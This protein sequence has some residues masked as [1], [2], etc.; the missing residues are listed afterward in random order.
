VSPRLYLRPEAEDE[1]GEAMAWCGERARFPYL[2]LYRAD[3]D[4]IIDAPTPS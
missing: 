4:E 2:V 1:N 3:G